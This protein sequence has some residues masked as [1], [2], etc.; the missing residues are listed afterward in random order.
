FAEL[1]TGVSQGDRVLVRK[2][3]PGEII[4]RPWDKAELASVGLELTADG[5]VMPMGGAKP[6]GG[7]GSK[8]AAMPGMKPGGPKV[9]GPPAAGTP[10]PAAP[11][12]DKPAAPAI[13]TPEPAKA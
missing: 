1:L 9:A 8:T 6:A 11:A 4:D 13:A 12:T 7:P 3:T 2:P 10:A 5:K